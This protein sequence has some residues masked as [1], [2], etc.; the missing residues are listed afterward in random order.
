MTAL[1]GDV[2]QEALVKPPGWNATKH[3]N[4]END[5]SSLSVAETAA[6]LK[7]ID[8]RKKS[9]SSLG[10][11]RWRAQKSNHVP[12]HHALVH[13]L[14]EQL[15]QNETKDEQEREDDDEEIESFIRLKKQGTQR[16]KVEPQI[17]LQRKKEEPDVAWRRHKRNDSSSNSSGE[18]D[19]PQ[20]PPIRKRCSDSNSNS[21]NEYDDRRQ[22]LLAKRREKKADVQEVAIDFNVEDNKTIEI[23]TTSYYANELKQ[24]TSSS[25]DSDSDES[26]RSSSEEEVQ[27]AKP[28]F[29]PKHRRNKIATQEE[30]EAATEDQRAKEE[31][32]EEKRKLESR[33]MLAQ[34][35]AATIISNTSQVDVDDEAGGS[36]N[37][38]PDDEDPTDPI[39]CELERDAWEVREL[40]RLFETDDLRELQQ[41]EQREYERRKHMSDQARMEE[42]SV[43]KQY[44]KPEEKRDQIQNG[45]RSNLKQR[46]YHRGAF[47]MDNKEWTADDVRH[48]AKE[49]ERAATG[50]DKID[51]SKLPEI[52]QVKGFGLARMGTKYKGLSREDT[53]DKGFETIHIVRKKDRNPKH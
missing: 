19:E 41:T 5:V 52:M 20:T 36:T 22:R 25:D 15:E 4:N 30:K 46:Y 23:C 8:A 45:E 9:S 24:E 51:K 17:L 29:V 34:V 7:K 42:D 27:V 3:R 11:A 32:R 50:D 31:L 44:Q 14:E 35:V 18:E 21:E 16:E 47:Y 49:Y 2:M 33:M 43:L 37:N 48:K 39:D 1:L 26:A 6:L 10:G 53:T 12:Q 38:P 40:L 13:E 28:I